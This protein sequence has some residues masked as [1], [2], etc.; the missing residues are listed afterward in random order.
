MKRT[1]WLAA[2]ACAAVASAWS[3]EEKLTFWHTQG[4]ERAEDLNRIVEEYNAANPPMKVEPVYKGSYSDIFRATQTNLIAGNPP[5]LV[6]AYES[7]VAEY[8]E[9]SGRVVDLEPLMRDP[10]IG[11]S[12]AEID[13][14][15]PYFLEINR[16][17]QYGGA[18]LSFVF[19]KSLLSLFVNEDMVREAGFGGPAKTW[20]EFRE[21]CLAMKGIGKKG[22]PITVDASTLDG[23]FMSRGVNLVDY[24]TLTTRFDDPRVVETF[25]FLRE[26]AEAGALYMVDGD[27]DE[28]FKEFVQQNAPF[29]IRSTTRRPV[30]QSEIG[31][32]F[33]WSMNP[34][35]RA[36]GV[37]PM[38]VLYG[39]NICV[40]DNGPERVRAAWQFVKFFASPEITARWALASGYMPVRKSSENL[41][42]MQTWF[43]EHPVNRQS[44]DLIP[45]GRGEPTPRGWQAVRDEVVKAA[46][47]AI[48]GRGARSPEAIAQDLKAKAD[49]LLAENKE[50][51]RRGVT[52]IAIVAI[53]AAAVAIALF[54]RKASKHA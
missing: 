36:E 9:Q 17:E 49:A 32:K 30:L 25:A 21:Q 10:E 31:D 44:F 23:M 28:D 46:V 16:Y 3:A 48:T 50:P 27:S 13:D 12:Q 14:I 34:I 4:S 5:D 8:Q 7:M 42:I 33:R 20:S 35:P 53:L 40:F 47:E 51:A 11:M 54:K 24:D 22:Y 43:A 6:V 29:F 38:T 26:L 39:A 45:L 1:A 19:T 41:P 2:L 37:D 52:G 18:L 15:F